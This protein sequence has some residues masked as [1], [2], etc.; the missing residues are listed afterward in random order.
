MI[1]LFED[2]NKPDLRKMST[3]V[4]CIKN[5]GPNFK[6]G[7]YYK[8]KG[9]Y[10]DAQ[11][12]IEKYKIYDYVPIELIIKVVI[13]DNFKFEKTFKINS[14]FEYFQI[15]ETEEDEFIKDTKKYNL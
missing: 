14:F 10:G 3:Y 2:F 11:G 9:M 5:C 7:A 8:I 15:L 1:K 6:K 4:L 12:A 13:I